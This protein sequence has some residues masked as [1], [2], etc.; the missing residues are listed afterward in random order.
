MCSYSLEGLAAGIED[1]KHWRSGASSKDQR[2]V[3]RQDSEDRGSL[4]SLTE[5]GPE[6][7]L[8]ECRSPGIQVRHEFELPSQSMTFDFEITELSGRGN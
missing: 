6:S 8:G 1:G 2:G 4:M 7:D 5:E 3:Q